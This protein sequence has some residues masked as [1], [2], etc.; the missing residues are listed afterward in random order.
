MGRTSLKV[1]GF[2]PLSYKWSTHASFLPGITILEHNLKRS[3]IL[4]G[5]RNTRFLLT[6]AAP[7]FSPFSI[8]K[9]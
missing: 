3:V 6:P 8:A 4:Q 5:Y 9:V 1:D 7:P 2:P